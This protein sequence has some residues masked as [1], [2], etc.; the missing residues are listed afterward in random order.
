VQTFV[1][2]GSELNIKKRAREIQGRG[3]TLA[4]GGDA[5][6]VSMEIAIRRLDRLGEGREGGLC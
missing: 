4:V 3:T 2:L 5:V 1:H 6:K